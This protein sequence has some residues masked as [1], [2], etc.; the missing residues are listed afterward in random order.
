MLTWLGNNLPSVIAGA[1]IIAVL[2]AVIC[3]MIRNKKQGKSSCGCS[4]CGG[5]NGC[6]GG[7][8][9]K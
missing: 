5:C 3:C 8:G 1:V 7:C 6:G 9:Q 2:A 4:G